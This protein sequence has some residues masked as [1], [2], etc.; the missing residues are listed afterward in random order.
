M[1]EAVETLLKRLELD[2]YI[3]R[4]SQ[5]LQPEIDVLDVEQEMGVLESLYTSLDLGK[6]DVALKALKLSEEHYL[7]G[8]WEDSI[9]N[10][11]KFHECT[12]REVAAA[13][14]SNKGASLPQDT[15]IKAN[16]VRKYLLNENLLG[17]SE[18]EA[19]DKLYRLLSN[20]GSHPY[21]AQN[22]QARLLRQLALTMSQFVMLRFQGELDRQSGTT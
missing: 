11:R 6:T 21:M 2:G 17:H 1:T 10:S 8:L 15:Y 19:L 22:D 5:L 9:N 14:A 16:E 12:L 20:T 13:H 7:S 3:Y 18:Y 4:D